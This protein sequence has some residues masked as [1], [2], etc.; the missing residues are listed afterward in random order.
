MDLGAGYNKV[1]TS[2]TVNVT[3]G[4]EDQKGYEGDKSPFH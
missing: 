1:V 3:I 4:V 2:E